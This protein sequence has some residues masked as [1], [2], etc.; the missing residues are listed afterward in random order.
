MNKADI[1]AF[2]HSINKQTKIGL[3]PYAPESWARQ[4]MCF[5]NVY[6]KIEKSGGR[7]QFGWMFNLRRAAKIL[8]NPEYVIA[9]HH[10]VWHELSTGRLFDITPFH[11]NAFHHPLTDNNDVVFLPDDNAK[12]IMVNRVHISLPS[13]FHSLGESK[14]MAA[15]IEFLIEDE[16]KE[17]QRFQKGDIKED[18]FSLYLGSLPGS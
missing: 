4:T 5:Y 3:V 15:Y 10:A 8:G 13:K 11:N 18:E 16:H 7:V 17:F 14:E 2:A 9:I 6:E 1:N 12:P